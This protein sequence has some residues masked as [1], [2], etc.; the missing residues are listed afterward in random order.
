MFLF[1]N[2]NVSYL[3][4]H[5]FNLLLFIIACSGYDT[6]KC[7]SEDSK[8]IYDVIAGNFTGK[9]QV[10]SAGTSL[11]TVTMVTSSLSVVSTISSGGSSAT[12]SASLL[13]LEIMKL[14]QYINVNY[15]SNVIA[16][17]EFLNQQS[18]LQLLKVPNLLVTI[19]GSNDT[20]LTANSE[21]EGE[22]K[23]SLYGV[24]SFFLLNY[25]D[26]LSGLFCMILLVPFLAIVKRLQQKYTPTSRIIVYT[27]QVSI[28]LQ[29]NYFISFFLGG[30]IDLLFNIALQL[31]FFD[32]SQTS[33]SK[34]SLVSLIAA[35]ITCFNFIGLVVFFYRAM[36]F[37]H[38][39]Y[40][41]QHP[42]LHKGAA[43][44]MEQAEK[45][46][47]EGEFDVSIRAQYWPAISL[48][49][50]ILVI[51]SITLLSEIPILQ[52]I[53]T[54]L[55][56]IGFFACLLK[57]RF[58]RR[59]I[60][61]DIMIVNEVSNMIICLLFLGYAVSDLIPH[62]LRKEDSEIMGWVIIGLIGL[63]IILSMGFQ[64][65]ETVLLVKI[66]LGSLYKYF[67][68]LNS[69]AIAANKILNQDPVDPVVPRKLSDLA[70]ATIN[71]NRSMSSSQIELTPQ[72]RRKS[73]LKN[74]KG[75][76]SKIL[77]DQESMQISFD[78]PES[79]LNLSSQQLFK[80]TRAKVGNIQNNQKSDLSIIDL[81]SNDL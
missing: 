50:T 10:K 77:S 1:L 38:E 32:Y 12:A 66:V 76:N 41:Q 20:A 54:L 24:S 23:F 3:I 31:R 72:I 56:N 18:I 78:F 2:A 7:A 21:V 70:L 29:W 40:I 37:K 65:V 13:S 19:S 75:R 64:L 61:Q 69:P 59:R 80:K 73:K 5:Y 28:F 22:N 68:R 43:I 81:T 57:W 79:S 26:S 14:Y 25:G 67:K 46:N 6:T 8:S 52:C 51:L 15:P 9:E 74:L 44:L 63:T 4:T 60:Q 36:G 39:N 17:F 71:A 53:L 49:R 45:E 47:Q 27:E 48:T 30:S 11:Q 55:A 42:K 35:I 34:I 58:F 33:S 62:K 16:F